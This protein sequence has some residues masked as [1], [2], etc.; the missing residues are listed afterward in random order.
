M[1]LEAI[2]VRRL[3]IIEIILGID[4]DEALAKIENAAI[5]IKDQIT[6]KP[7]VLDAVKPIRTNVSLEQ[8]MEEQNYK[9]ISYKEFRELADQLE[10]KEPIE[11]LLAMLTK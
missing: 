9:P 2:K 3:N 11:E 8:I 7:N 6:D 10:L 4:N 5:E 1:T